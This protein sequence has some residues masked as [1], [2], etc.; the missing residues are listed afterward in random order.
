MPLWLRPVVSSGLWKLLGQWR[1]FLFCICTISNTIGFSC[2]W[3]FY[4]CNLSSLLG[5]KKRRKKKEN[6][7][8]PSMFVKYMTNIRNTFFKKENLCFSL[9][10][11]GNS[12]NWNNFHSCKE[13]LYMRYLRKNYMALLPK[14]IFNKIYLFIFCTTCLGLE[15]LL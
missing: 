12:V 11:Y 15:K 8:L 14:G 6:D 5:K 13:Y 3:D 7:S 1:S 10:K 4:H 2:L 9:F